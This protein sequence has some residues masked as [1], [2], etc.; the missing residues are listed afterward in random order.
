MPFQKDHT[1]DVKD[2]I[3]SERTGSPMKLILGVLSRR[4]TSEKELEPVVAPATKITVPSTETKVG[5]D[6]NV[7]SLSISPIQPKSL[8]P[9]SMLGFAMVSRGEIGFLISSV[10]ESAGI[11]SGRSTPRPPNLEDT[12]QS[13][14]MFIVV[15]WAIF[16]CTFIGPVA[17][18]LLVRRVK[19]LEKGKDAGAI[20]VLGSWGIEITTDSGNT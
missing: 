18:G 4:F 10:A 20:N 12:Q 8:Y 1:I 16:L 15:T 9:A 14:D 11:W 17:I 5:D 13:S 6:E 3:K 7:I 2:R 19:S